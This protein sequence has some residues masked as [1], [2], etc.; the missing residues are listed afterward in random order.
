MGHGI[1][2]SRPVK[3]YQRWMDR[4]P[5]RLSHLSAVLRRCLLQIP[6]SRR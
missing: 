6:E 5:P 3:A 2:D 1:L 4:D